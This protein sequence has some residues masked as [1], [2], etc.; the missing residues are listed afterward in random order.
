MAPAGL[1]DLL[2]P[3]KRDI[4]QL[5]AGRKRRSGIVDL[6]TLQTLAHRELEGI[7]HMHL[8]PVRHTMSEDAAAT[9]L[10]RRDLIVHDTLADPDAPPEAPVQAVLGRVAA[11]DEHL[12][13]LRAGLISTQGLNAAV[14]KGGTGKKLQKAVIDGLRTSDGPAR[15]VEEHR[16]L[17]VTP[18]HPDDPR[19]IPDMEGEPHW[20]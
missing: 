3:Q 9:V 14:L 13:A 6:V 12:E 19:F 8:G 2:G 10:I 7:L 11:E 4:A 18:S 1:S 20:A 17:P 5:G 15:R 16:V